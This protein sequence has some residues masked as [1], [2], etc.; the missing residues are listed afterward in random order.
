MGK[1]MY[2]LA[3]GLPIAGF[4]RK[5]FW[6][7]AYR[8]TH[9]CEVAKHVMIVKLL[10]YICTDGS[11]NQYLVSKH[12]VC[13][14]YPVV[15]R[16]VHADIRKYIEKRLDIHNDPHCQLRITVNSVGFDVPIEKADISPNVRAYINRVS[17]DF[18]KLV[19][20][21]LQLTRDVS[22]VP[23]II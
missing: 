2:I 22:L 7:L 18:G 1:L 10:A 6:S 5:A 16:G 21:G 15:G 12:K 4:M 14:K 8:K 9:P 23:V 20:G 17:S 19:K 11:I 13:T 3:V